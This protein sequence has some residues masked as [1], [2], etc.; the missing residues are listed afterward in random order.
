MYNTRKSHREYPKIQIN[1]K[2][3]G[4]FIILTLD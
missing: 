4:S 1:E 3:Q 2:A